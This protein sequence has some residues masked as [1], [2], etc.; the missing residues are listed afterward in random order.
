MPRHRQHVPL[1]IPSQIASHAV[2]APVRRDS[3]EVAAPPQRSRQSVSRA[4]AVSEGGGGGREGNP[5]KGQGRGLGV[6]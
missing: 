6:T 5:G 1:A 4:L 3:V 2:N